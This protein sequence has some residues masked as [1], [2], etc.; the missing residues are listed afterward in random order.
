MNIIQCKALECNPQDHK[1][2]ERGEKRENQNVSGCP[3]MEHTA[4]MTVITWAS[5]P[6]ILECNG[7]DILFR[8]QTSG[9]LSDLGSL[10]CLK[11]RMGFV[12]PQSAHQKSISHD[13]LEPVHPLLTPPQPRSGIPVLSL[14]L[15]Q[16]LGPTATPLSL[17]WP[18]W[19]S[20]SSSAQCVSV[21]STCEVS[22]VKTNSGL[23][24]PPYRQSMRLL[25][26]T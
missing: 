21:L 22:A 12:H 25:V 2:R 24:A 15:L 9:F 4:S 19:S 3:Q 1:H 18:L 8:T 5:R 11:D 16:L 26:N 14:S 10:R 17:V 6:T 20:S 23:T 7:C 13:E